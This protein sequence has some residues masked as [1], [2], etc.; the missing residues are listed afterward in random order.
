[1]QPRYEKFVKNSNDMIK[2]KKALKA[3]LT[4]EKASSE[5][6]L[7]ETTDKKKFT[8]DSHTAETAALEQ[9]KSDCKFLFDN[10]EIRQEHMSGEIE[11]LGEAKAFLKGMKID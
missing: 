4:E 7:Q 6:K 5:E 1:M 9:W 10:F 8:T 2:D 3:Q 11:A